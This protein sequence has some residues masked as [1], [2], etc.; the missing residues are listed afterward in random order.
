MPGNLTNPLWQLL[1]GQS[2]WHEYFDMETVHAALDQ[3]TNELRFNREST[4]MPRI[5]SLT[6]ISDTVTQAIRAYGRGE[7]WVPELTSIVSAFISSRTEMN[8]LRAVVSTSGYP[9]RSTYEQAECYFNEFLSKLDQ[10][11]LFAFGSMPSHLKVAAKEICDSNDM[12]CFFENQVLFPVDL[13]ATHPTT[14]HRRLITEVM[15]LTPV[16]TLQPGNS[17][18]ESSLA[19]PRATRRASIQSYSVDATKQLLFKDNNAAFSAKAVGVAH[20]GRNI[21]VPTVFAQ[22]EEEIVSG[23]KSK[24]KTKAPPQHNF[25]AL[26]YFGIELEVERKSSTPESIIQEVADTLGH[27]YVILKSDGS[28]RDGFEIVTAPA[29]LEYHRLKGNWPAFFSGPA[30]KLTSWESGRAGMHVH[31]SRDSFTPLHLSKFISFINMAENRADI[32]KIAGRTSSYATFTDNLTIVNKFKN[33]ATKYLGEKVATPDTGKLVPIG[34]RVTVASAIHNMGLSRGAVNVG[35]K[36]T[37]EVRIFRGNLNPIGFMKN[38]EFVAAAHEFTHLATFRTKVSRRDI[39]EAN[40]YGLEFKNFIEWLS[41]ENSG[42]YENLKIWLSANGYTLPIKEKISAAKLLEYKKSLEA[43]RARP[44][45]RAAK[46]SRKP[47]VPID[48][49]Q[50]LI[51]N[52]EISQCA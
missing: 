14:G 38:L 25:S 47:I 12:P 28:L 19:T 3:Y 22:T 35:K 13:W 23:F 31:I 39:D 43:R 9:Q 33:V 6:L 15:S 34:A 51:S 27:D 21:P 37:V 30:K 52:E 48:K 8:R 44:S 49:T 16:L 24:K 7:S 18:V 36:H 26:T 42:N 46:G 45:H 32:T 4:T 11:S 2:S 40:A 20:G 17:Y 10:C 50:F 29:T 1:G 5:S 41:K